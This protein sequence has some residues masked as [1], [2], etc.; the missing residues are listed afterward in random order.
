MSQL[1]LLAHFFLYKL[2]C[3]VVSN[4][5]FFYFLFVDGPPCIDDVGQHKGDE[6]ADDGH[7]GQCE[8]AGARINNG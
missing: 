2:I 6:D 4:L 8:L 3:V 1:C 5:L 7:R